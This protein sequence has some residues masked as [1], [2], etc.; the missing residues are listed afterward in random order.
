MGMSAIARYASVGKLQQF[1]APIGVLL[2]VMATVVQIIQR[3]N[4]TC[5]Q[6]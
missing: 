5:Q 6:F 4:G 1:T 2:L 3:R